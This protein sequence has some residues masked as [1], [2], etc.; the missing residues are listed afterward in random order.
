MGDK[1]R[2]KLI[3]VALI[4]IVFASGCLTGSGNSQGSSQ[5]STTPSSTPSTV[6]FT[7]TSSSRS[8][9]SSTSSPLETSSTMTT[10][11]TPDYL[12]E[13]IRSLSGISSYLAL[14]NTT[15][16]STVRIESRGVVRVEN[17]SVFSNSTAFYDLSNERMDVNMT[18]LTKPAGARVFTRIILSGDVAR[19]Y[20]FG[21][22]KEFHSGQ[23][24]FDVIRKTFE[25][26][27]LSLA[28]EASREGSCRVTAG[29]YYVLQCTSKNAFEELI[30][31]AVG[32]P[33]G[34]EVSVT[35]GRVEVVF[36]NLR[37]V[38]GRIEVG[39]VVSTTYTDASGGTFR[40]VQRGK[41]V[42]TF[43]VIRSYS[44]TSS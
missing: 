34:S 11:T 18:V 10:T 39:F 21:E 3:A 1:V 6:S 15:I 12:D 19:V 23:E 32:A 27:P 42:E 43:A 35:L 20:S 4:L 38:R 7:S 29:E 13:L 31:S 26:N 37:P 33:E 30:K 9:T 22:W 17:V 16:N 44:S 28:L 2:G 25:S 14:V 40:L 41:I 8:A 24:G 36:H 5:P